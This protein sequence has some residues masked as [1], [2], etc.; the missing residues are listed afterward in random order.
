MGGLD[1]GH[2]CLKAKRSRGSPQS[3]NL[4]KWGVIKENLRIMAQTKIYSEV[5]NYLT[6]TGKCR[7][8]RYIANLIDSATIIGRSNLAN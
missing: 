1:D 3:K 5:Y 6:M 4:G 2:K 7:D 8:A